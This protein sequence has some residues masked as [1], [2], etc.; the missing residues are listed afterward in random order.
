MCDANCFDRSSFTSV[1]SALCPCVTFQDME[2][3]GPKC[4]YCNITEEDLQKFCSSLYHLYEVF[5]FVIDKT[6]G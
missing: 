5:I 1:H 3:I 4:E 2:Q 6:T